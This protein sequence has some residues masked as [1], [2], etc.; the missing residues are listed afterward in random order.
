MFSRSRKRLGTKHKWSKRRDNKALGDNMTEVEAARY[1]MSSHAAFQT[2]E[3]RNESLDAVESR[4]HDGV[5]P[6]KLHQRAD[7]YLDTFEGLYPRSRPRRGAD[8]ME[9]GVGVGY[10]MEA[11]LRRYS[12]RKIVG[13]DIAAGMID[14]ARERLERDSV[15]TRAI[16]FVHY[17]GVTVPLPSNSLDFIYSVASLQHAPRP[18]C[19]RAMM[20]AY[21][22]VKPSGCV[23]VH[24]LAYSHFREHM[25]PELFSQE[26]DRQIQG[27][28]GHWHHYYSADELDA[29][30]RYGIGVRNL[31]IREQW[32]SL[33]VC[34][35]G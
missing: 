34:F 21:R 8:L 31:R 10:I 25:T 26:V 19:F 29:V 24:L 6:D 12:P 15:H 22:L 3:A 4:I 32:G 5:P 28:E 27:G 1:G 11:A 17:D 13:L 35:D 18:Y 20:E 14:K 2:W 16:E 23:Y 7:D 30:L 33:F 9:I